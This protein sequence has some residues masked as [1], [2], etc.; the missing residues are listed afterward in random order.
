MAKYKEQFDKKGIS[1]LIIVWDTT[2]YCVIV[3]VMA[4]PFILNGKEQNSVKR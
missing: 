4:M 2:Y 3:V 1:T